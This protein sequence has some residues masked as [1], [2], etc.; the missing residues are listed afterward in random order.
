MR[1]SGLIVIGSGPGG[2]EAVRA[3]RETDADTS[4]IMITADPDPPY[5]RP[6]LTKDYLRGETELAELWLAEEEWFAEHG[7]EL[8]LGTEVVGVSPAD[9]LVRLVDGSTLDYRDLVLATGSRP[10]PME[11]PGGR[12]PGWCT[13]ATG[14]AVTGCGRW[15]SSGRGGWR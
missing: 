1:A 9:R 6:P 8:R 12:I 14:P 7:V 3:F 4:I 5:N 10:R 11:V 2:M 15:P 13:S